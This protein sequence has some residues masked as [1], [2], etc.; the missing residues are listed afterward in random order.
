MVSRTRR[1]GLSL[2]LALSL[3]VPALE[4]AADFKL[5]VVD[6]RRAV[7]SSSQGKEAE[8]TMSQLQEKKKKE[9]EPRGARCK[10]MQED[11]EAQ[12]FVLSE[13]A[14]QE[15]AIEFQ[16]CQRDL[17]RDVQAA[18]DEMAVQESKLMAPIAKKLE[19]AVKAIGKD[20]AFDLVVDRSTPGVLYTADSLDITELVIQKLNGN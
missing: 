9:L 16:S 20:K 4:A 12:R 5:A 3:F 1:A 11:L 15:K 10:K 6:R 13:D 18:R 14:L 2:G 17:E 7:M 19:E 8:K